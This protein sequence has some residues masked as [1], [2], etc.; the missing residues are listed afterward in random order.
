MFDK[1]STSADDTCVN[2]AV[3]CISWDQH[4]YIRFVHSLRPEHVISLAANKHNRCKGLSTDVTVMWKN[5]HQANSNSMLDPSQS[6]KLGDDQY[7]ILI[8]TSVLMEI[9][10]QFITVDLP[11]L[12][13]ALDDKSPQI[14]CREP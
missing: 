3:S 7:R 2:I 4:V 12:N 10:I 11:N 9:K 6:W 14:H 5:A 13:T 1:P 8:L